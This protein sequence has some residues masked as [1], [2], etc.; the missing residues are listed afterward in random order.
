MSPVSEQVVLLASG[1]QLSEPGKP[2]T[3]AGP[4]V[5]LSWGGVSTCG[6]SPSL[7][8]SV[9]QVAPGRWGFPA[10]LLLTGLCCDSHSPSHVYLMPWSGEATW[11]SP[12]ILGRG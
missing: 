6:W 1:Q 5:P 2:A 4:T 8:L 3:L 12:H 7:F 9:L 10:Q 11:A